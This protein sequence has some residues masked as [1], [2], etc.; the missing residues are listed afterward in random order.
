[1]LGMQAAGLLGGAVIVETMFAWPGVG[2]L[3]VDAIWKRDFFVVM[4]GVL[5]LTG[6]YI[7]VNLIV[8]LAYGVLDPRIRYD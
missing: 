7:L 1:M 2:R 5:I 3:I 6:V 4:G 8:D